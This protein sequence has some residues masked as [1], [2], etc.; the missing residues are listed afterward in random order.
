MC[1]RRA[2]ERLP[3]F[4]PQLP[5][6]DQTIT[7]LSELEALG[8]SHFVYGA[9][10]REAYVERGIDP[11][12][13]QL[14]AALGRRDLFTKTAW[15]YDATFSY[16]LY[17]VR[18]FGSRRELPQ[19]YARAEGSEDEI[20]FG[21][22]IRVWAHGV[23][24]R[25]IYLNTPLTFEPSWRALR[26]LAADYEIAL[27]L[28]DARAGATAAEW[29]F[30]PGEHRHGSYSTRNWEVD[31]Y[32]ND[33]QIL[34]LDPNADIARGDYTFALGVWDAA[35]ERYLPLTING[36]AAGEFYQLNGIYSLRT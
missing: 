10:A 6:V 19:H 5:I 13:T 14:I 1:W 22:R 23:Y 16:E 9:K 26:P 30:R 31:E 17:R 21:D 3:F 15:H 12:R 28:V 29:R 2:R 24:P 36:E 11:Q 33:L 34:R 32:I 4:F 27:R 35:A 7:E 8:A 25:V 18:D 20:V